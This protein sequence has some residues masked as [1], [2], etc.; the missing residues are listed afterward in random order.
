MTRQE[1]IDSIMDYFDFHK[2]HE[3]MDTFG[4][5]WHITGVPDVVALRKHA[6]QQLNTVYDGLETESDNYI[7][8]SGGLHCEGVR[9]TEDNSI[10]LYLKFVPVEWDVN[11]TDDDNN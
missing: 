4:W 2:V 9:H 7:V 6:R 3:Y 8:S 1:M 10:S 5:K 11:S